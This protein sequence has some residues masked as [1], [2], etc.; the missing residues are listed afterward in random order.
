MEE[1]VPIGIALLGIFKD[2]KEVELFLIDN[3]KVD[4]RSVCLRIG[5]KPKTIRSD[6]FGQYANIDTTTMQGTEWD[7][8]TRLMSGDGWVGV[9][10]EA[11]DPKERNN[12]AKYK[13]FGRK[14]VRMY[15]HPD[16]TQEDKDRGWRLLQSAVAIESADTQVEDDLDDLM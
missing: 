9:Q 16:T 2:S 14:S 4:T 7:R 8:M 15:M 11:K 3:P 5:I 12:P 10:S 1:E 13:V 6:V